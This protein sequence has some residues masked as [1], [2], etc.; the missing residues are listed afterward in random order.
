MKIED[1]FSKLEKE[2]NITAYEF[3]KIK[4]ISYPTLQKCL[5]GERISPHTARS[6]CKM[7][8]GKVRLE[9]L[10]IKN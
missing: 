10:K 9:D 1:F 2:F 7:T 6:I 3:C 5:K 4:N 8:N